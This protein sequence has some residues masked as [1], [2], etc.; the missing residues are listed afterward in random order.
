MQPG[1]A[2]GLIKSYS[3]RS[4]YG[5][6]TNDTTG[7][8]VFFGREALPVEF[9]VGKCDGT[10]V[11]YEAT[12]NAKGKFQATNIRRTR[13]TQH[14]DVTSGKVKSWNANKGFGFLTADDI[15]GDIFFARDRLPDRLKDVHA[16]ENLTMV[17]EL[18][19]GD[20]GKLQARNMKTPNDD[21]PQGGG[22]NKRQFQGNDMDMGPSKRM[23]VGFGGHINSGRVSGYVKSYS[24]QTGY[25]FI[26]SNQHNQDIVVYDKEL[27]SI[28]ELTKG[29]FVEFELRITHNGKPQATNVQKGSGNGVGQ[30]QR[31]QQPQQQQQHSPR[32]LNEYPNLTVHDLKL[33]ADQLNAQDLGELAAHATQALQAKM[34]GML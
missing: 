17:F 8:D 1:P 29:D 25:G 5:F 6:I 10:E 9:Q 11:A 20:D 28:G 31:Q 18:I 4:G 15:E 16:L 7:E 22:M 14:G 2:Q 3:N 32:P 26:V 27:Q 24:A 23:N 13:P 30:P 33:Y 34:A 21:Q 19:K 12:T